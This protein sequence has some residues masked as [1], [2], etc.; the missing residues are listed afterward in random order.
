MKIFPFFLTSDNFYGYR[1]WEWNL[2]SFKT[3]ITSAQFLLA[4]MVFTEKFTVILMDL[5]LSVTQSFLL[6]DVKSSLSHTFI[7]LTI[8]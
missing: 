1:N 3:F 4:A 6:S 2:W 7:V 5:L 8:I